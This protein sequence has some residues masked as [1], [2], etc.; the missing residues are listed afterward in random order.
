MTAKAMLSQAPGGPETLA[1]TEVPMPEPARGEV[2]VAIRAASANFPDTLIIRDLYQYK[3]DRPFAPGGEIAG[4]VDAVGPDVTGVAVGDRVMALTIYGGFATHIVLPAEKVWPVPDAMP[5]DEAAAFLFTYGTSYYALTDRGHLAQGDTLLVLG[6]AGGI[7]ASAVEL[8]KALGA[9]VIAA[10]SS[11]EKAAFC[12]ELGADS[13]LI[14]PPEMDEAGQ[15]AFGR[16]IK[17]A[18]PDGLDAVCDPVG[19]PYAEPALRAMAWGG[20]FLVVGFPAGIP[21]IPLNLPLLKGCD[22]TGVF[23]GAFTAKDP[24]RFAED[25]ADMS[26]LYT[27]GRIAPRISARLPLAE[28]AQALRLIETRKV[29]GKVVLTVD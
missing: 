20:R 15:R 21:K 11:E 26:R 12:R 5:F 8:G 7:G 6:A 17:A 22:I 1:L 14:Y 28:A 18:A 25:V 2:R 27:E 4:T 29:I 16:E 19:G 13:V 10:V 23:W 9:R 3:P 24:A